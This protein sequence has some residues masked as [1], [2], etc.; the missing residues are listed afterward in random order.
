MC[1]FWMECIEPIRSTSTSV[2]GRSLTFVSRG[3]VDDVPSLTCA[4]LKRSEAQMTVLWVDFGFR[5][6]MLNLF[7]IDPARFPYS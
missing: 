5:Y 7:R 6:E 2:F 4:L 3:S 1:I